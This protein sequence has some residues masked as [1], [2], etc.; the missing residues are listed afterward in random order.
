MV[1]ICNI[2]IFVRTLIYQQ[3]SRFSQHNVQ[4]ICAYIK[5]LK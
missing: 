2:K 4:N 1:A 5:V 3:K